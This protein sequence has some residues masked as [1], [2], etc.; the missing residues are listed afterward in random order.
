MKVNSIGAS[1]YKNN[2]KLSNDSIN[3]KNNNETK[4]NDSKTSIYKKNTVESNGDNISKE[5]EETKEKIETK[6]I[7]INGSRVLLTLKDGKVFSSIKISEDSN[8]MEDIN[9][10]SSTESI[11]EELNTVQ[12]D[13]N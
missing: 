13:S 11:S 7:T 4:K 5:P 10:K 6:I 2:Y 3:L 9:K 12:E 1:N 8:I